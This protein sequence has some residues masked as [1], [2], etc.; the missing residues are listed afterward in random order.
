M[1]ILT[2]ALIP[3]LLTGCVSYQWV[4]EGSTL[5]QRE[6]DETSCM[7]KSLREL[8]PDNVIT[9]R[10]IS[11]DKK[12]KYQ[13]A[14]YSTQ[15]ANEDGRELLVKDCMLTKGWKQIRKN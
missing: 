1:K 5:Q 2:T 15:D 6:V 12:G 14:S 4:K 8:P 3:V 13:D 10:N 11:E 7:A 9:R